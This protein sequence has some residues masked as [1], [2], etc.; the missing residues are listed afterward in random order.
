MQKYWILVVESALTAQG[1]EAARGARAKCIHS[2]LNSKLPS[3]KKLGVIVIK[4]QIRTNRMHCPPSQ[5]SSAHLGIPTTL[6]YLSWHLLKM[7]SPLGSSQCAKVI[8]AALE[9]GLIN[10]NT[11]PNVSEAT[12]LACYWF[13]VQD[14]ILVDLR[15]KGLARLGNPFGIPR[16]S[17]IIPILDLLDS[18]IF[19]GIM[20]FRS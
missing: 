2:K 14:L 10:L 16:N 3:R 15:T 11:K 9:T 13:F 5:D 12:Y 6:K 8:Q 17:A 1:L 7:S 19:I 20:F 4:Q 18:G